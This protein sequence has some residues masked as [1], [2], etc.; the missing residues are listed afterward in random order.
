MA[1]IIGFT[2]R[3]I[4]MLE[5]FWSP[6]F[7]RSSIYLSDYF[8]KEH[9]G[10]KNVNAFY[11][12]VLHNMKDIKYTEINREHPLVIKSFGEI[13]PNENNIY[14]SSKKYFMVDG[15]S[16]KKLCLNSSTKKGI[17]T[18][19]Y[20]MK[21]EE[22][23]ILMKDYIC[24]YKET[25]M[26]RKEEEI[27][28]D[29]E[30]LRLNDKAYKLQLQQKD[31][32]I[33]RHNRFRENMTVFN[34][35]IQHKSKIEYLYIA[36]TRHYANTN[37]F[38]IGKTDTSLKK[39][40]STYNTGRPL[41]DTYYFCKSFKCHNSS[42]LEN[43]ISSLLEN[44]RER[45]NREMYQMHYKPLEAI[46]DFICENYDK[47][48]DMLNE[49][50]NSLLSKYCD[51]APFIPEP[52]EIEEVKL[53]SF[54]NNDK[55]DKIRADELTEEEFCILKEIVERYVESKT[56]KKVVIFK[57]NDKTLIKQID[58]KDI[59]DSMDKKMTT[60]DWRKKLKTFCEGFKVTDKFVV[61][62]K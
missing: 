8:I 53:I 52:I 4:E 9:L 57:D 30:Q 7:N 21:V 56:Y 32:E 15:R 29:L 61:I 2:N 27:K 28:N 17:E 10:Y 23:A 35:N 19:N 42:H 11:R 6:T 60:L 45:K 43:R 12:D 55:K 59:K 33:K 62:S 25:V 14:K 34:Q 54:Q 50:I 5:M 1:E 47:E 18:K 37:R 46:F 16:F 44:F 40:L 22:L 13:S 36:T 51:E 3:E 58:W 39:R 38:K 41:D 31:E 26:R 20:Y 24:V 49:L 48:I